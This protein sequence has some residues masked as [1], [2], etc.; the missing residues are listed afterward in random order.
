MNGSTSQYL[1][2]L[3]LLLEEGV[4]LVPSHV[5][6][7]LPSDGLDRILYLIVIEVQFQHLCHFL[8]IVK[9]NPLLSILLD[10]LERLSPSL[11]TVWMSLNIS[12]LYDCLGQRG[13]EVLKPHPFSLKRVGDIDKRSV[14]KL[15]RLI[16]A[17]RASGGHNLP[18]ISFSLVIGIEIEQ[19]EEVSDLRNIKGRVI[20]NDWFSKD[21]LSLVLDDGFPID[22]HGYIHRNII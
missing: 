9:R 18:H 2:L 5:L 15:M 10:Q 17:Q 4:E 14:Y 8:E 19:R 3:D 22:A 12:K 20:D 13:E 1:L 21:G 11:F 6:F 7:A 16:V